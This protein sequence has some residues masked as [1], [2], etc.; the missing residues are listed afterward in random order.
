MDREEHATH[1]AAIN[2]STSEII[3][4][5]VRIDQTG[6]KRHVD[7]QTELPIMVCAMSIIATDVGTL[8]TKARILLF[9]AIGEMQEGV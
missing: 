6:Q 1:G 3:H 9:T 7:L 5:S 4:F 8:E 2:H